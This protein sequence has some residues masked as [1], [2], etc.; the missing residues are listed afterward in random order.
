MNRDRIQP[1]FLDWIETELQRRAV[2]V[3]LAA[4]FLAAVCWSAWA[5]SPL[6]AEVLA[7]GPNCPGADPAWLGWCSDAPRL[8]GW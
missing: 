5:Y 6:L 7:T 2:Q 3:L 1:D 4:S 8:E